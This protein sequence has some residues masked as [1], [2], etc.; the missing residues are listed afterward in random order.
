MP[1]RK[2]RAIIIGGGPVG[3][4]LANGLDRAGLDFLL[5]ERHPTIVSESGAAIMLWPHNVRV[6]DQL[7]L[8][9]A[10]EGRYIPLRKKT[11]AHLDGTPTRTVPTFKYLMEK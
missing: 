9:D 6:F 3:L 10:C 7:G 1:E 4:A 11:M 8:L 5:V 2:F